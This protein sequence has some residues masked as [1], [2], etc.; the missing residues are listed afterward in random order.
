MFEAEKIDKGKY[1]YRGYTIQRDFSTKKRGERWKIEGAEGL[2]NISAR[3]K[4]MWAA[5]TEIDRVAK[6]EDLIEATEQP[7]VKE[8]VDHEVEIADTVEETP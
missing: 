1:E 6:V 2:I 4:H 7:A 3:F 8:T 5:R